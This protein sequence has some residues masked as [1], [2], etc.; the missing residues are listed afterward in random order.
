MLH[1]RIAGHHGKVIALQQKLLR[2]HGQPVHVRV[3]LH[4]HVPGVLTEEH[5]PALLTFVQKP[6][7]VVL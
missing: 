7:K 5:Q 1:L 2:L 6:P 4:K 3:V